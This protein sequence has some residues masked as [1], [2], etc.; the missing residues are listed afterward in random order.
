M[1]IFSSLDEKISILRLEH[2]TLH[3]FVI[4]IT[5]MINHNHQVPNLLLRLSATNFSA[6]ALL[7]NCHFD[8]YNDNDKKLHEI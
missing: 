1:E 2:K 3:N 5:I 8:R 4:I 7:I 6:P